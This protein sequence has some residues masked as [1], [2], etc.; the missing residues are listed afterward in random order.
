MSNKSP[1]NNRKKFFHKLLA[2]T[3]RKFVNFLGYAGLIFIFYGTISTVTGEQ[4]SWFEKYV[5]FLSSL[6]TILGTLI[7]ASSI[8]LYTP[9]VHEPEIF[10]KW[11]SA[12][13]A[14]ILSITAIIVLFIKGQLPSSIVNGFALLGLAGGLFR[15]QKPPESY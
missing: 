2:V 3:F 12:P 10:S 7:T 6:L 9:T 11:I 5:D 1:I 4:W 14:I 8:Y 15:I 13:V